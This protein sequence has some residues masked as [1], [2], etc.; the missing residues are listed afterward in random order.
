MTESSAKE[1]VRDVPTQIFEKFLQAL[2]D[3]GMSTELIARFRS[4]LME[5][6]TFSEGALKDALLGKEPFL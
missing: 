2:G 6:R 5:D 3:A 4:T 1:V